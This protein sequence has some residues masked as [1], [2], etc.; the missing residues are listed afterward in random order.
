MKPDTHGA[1]SVAAVSQRAGTGLA[2]AGLDEPAGVAP[3]V[4]AGTGL[5][6]AATC[7]WTAAGQVC[8]AILELIPSANRSWIGTVPIPGSSAR[9]TQ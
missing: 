7:R 6:A 8:T 9:S 5:A 2:V 4:L 3:V 1:L